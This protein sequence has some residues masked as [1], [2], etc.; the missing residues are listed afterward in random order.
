MNAYAPL[1]QLFDPLN[2]CLSTEAAEKLAAMKQDEAIATRM[3]ELA[4]KA[5]EG[6]LTEVEQREYE[7]KVRAG[8]L[9]SF[10]QAKARLFLKSQTT[11]P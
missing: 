4:D 11:V 5:N 2:R 10:L 9:L 7:G 3:A 6:T 8:T 1:D